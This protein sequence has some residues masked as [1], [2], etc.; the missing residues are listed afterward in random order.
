MI[1]QHLLF[2]TDYTVTNTT[3]VLYQDRSDNRCTSQ[4]DWGFEETENDLDQNGS[5]QD[6]VGKPTD[7]QT[8]LPLKYEITTTIITKQ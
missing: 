7:K 8:I 1:P 2:T 3:S 6:L 5:L 4:N